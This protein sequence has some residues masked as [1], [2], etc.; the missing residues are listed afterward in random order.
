MHIIRTGCSSLNCTHAYLYRTAYVHKHIPTF[1][2]T[3]YIYI[4]VCVCEYEYIYVS[5]CE[6]EY[7]CT[8]DILFKRDKKFLS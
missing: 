8:F 5:E 2:Y 7:L 4:C 1:I 3:L 6:N